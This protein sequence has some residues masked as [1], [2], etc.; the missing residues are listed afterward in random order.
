MYRG[1]AKA[2]PLFLSVITDIYLNK[3]WNETVKQPVFLFIGFT[4]CLV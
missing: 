1:R 3:V 4:I 2:L